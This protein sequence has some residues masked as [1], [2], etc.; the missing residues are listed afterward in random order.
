[1]KAYTVGYSRGSYEDYR[2]IIV[3][4]TFDKKKA[5]KWCKKYNKMLIKWKRYYDKF[6]KDVGFKWYD[7]E[8]HGYEFYDRWHS[9]FELN[10][11][12]YKE[13]EIR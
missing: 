5:Q 4:V 2:E 10:G 12:S 3:F 6:T 1:M 13:Y 7:S 9:I 8:K 11:A